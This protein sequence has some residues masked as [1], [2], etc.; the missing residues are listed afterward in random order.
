M[1]TFLCR[2]VASKDSMRLEEAK[3]EDNRPNLGKLSNRDNRFS[4]KSI[5]SKESNVAPKCSMAGMANPRR[6]ISRSPNGL[7]R[8]SQEPINSADNLIFDSVLCELW[9]GWQC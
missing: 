8:C 9:G 4:D 3:M 7:V 1:G 5:L 2:L 6:I